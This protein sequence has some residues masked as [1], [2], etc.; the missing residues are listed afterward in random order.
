MRISVEVDT[1]SIEKLLR[2]VE[3]QMSPMGLSAFLTRRAGP[4]LRERM[5]GRFKGEGDSASGK[6]APLLPSTLRV[7]E[8]GIDAGIWPGISPAHPINKRSGDMESYLTRA[9]GEVVPDTQGATMHFPEVTPPSEG[10]MGWKLRTAQHGTRYE[11]KR[12]VFAVD[13]SDAAFLV[14]AFALDLVQGRTG[15]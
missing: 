14:T 13:E 4:L 6:W 7:R 10:E 3:I 11:V 9:R 1:T 8:W 2:N 15:E 5:A 12:P